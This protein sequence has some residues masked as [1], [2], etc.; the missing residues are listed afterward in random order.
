MRLSARC[1]LDLAS[2]GPRMPNQLAQGKGRNDL[3]APVQDSIALHGMRGKGR[4]LRRVEVEDGELLELLMAPIPA[5]MTI[6]TGGSTYH[7]LTLYAVIEE[8]LKIAGSK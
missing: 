7:A 6:M 4:A 5:V 8:D 2:S 3:G 1:F